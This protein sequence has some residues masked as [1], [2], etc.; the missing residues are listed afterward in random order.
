MRSRLVA[1][2]TLSNREAE[3]F[4]GILAARRRLLDHWPREGI[5]ARKRLA[6]DSTFERARRLVA[7]EDPEFAAGVADEV[8]ELA[9]TGLA[10]IHLSAVT[11]SSRPA[12]CRGPGSR[13]A[14]RHL[15]RPA[16]GPGA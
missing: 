12:S 5:A 3:A 14:G 8:I 13:G 9:R 1:A 15:R 7:I 4:R 10:P 11:T 2:L 6:A 16:G